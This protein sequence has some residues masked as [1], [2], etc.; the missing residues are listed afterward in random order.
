MG[1]TEVVKP[2]TLSLKSRC[3]SSVRI[4]LSKTWAAENLDQLTNKIGTVT[5]SKV[6]INKIFI[7]KL[8]RKMIV[9]SHSFRMV[10]SSLRQKMNSLMLTDTTSLT[11]SLKMIFLTATLGMLK[12]STCQK[13]ILHIKRNPINK[14]RKWRKSKIVVKS[15]TLP[16]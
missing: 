10:S 2:T 15:S 13:R 11:K 8:S 7:K 6:K 4:N 14:I 9:T 12:S 1:V 5:V 3:Q 16:Y